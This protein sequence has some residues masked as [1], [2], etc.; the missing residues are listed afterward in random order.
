[1][2]FKK[3]FFN[4]LPLFV[5][6]RIFLFAVAYLS[7]HL[8]PAFGATFPYSQERLIS[9][10][11]PHFIWAFGNFDGV[12]YLGIADMAYAA[13]YTQAFFPIFPV[14]IKLASTL[15]GGNLLIAALVVS[16]SAFLLALTIFYKLIAETY[17]S[18]TALWSAV[19]LLS[20]PTSFYFGAV[21]T[22][23]I[24]FLLVISAFY[25]ANRNK[26]ILASIIGAFASATRLVGVFLAVALALKKKTNPFPPLL[27]VPLGLV[28]YMIYLK[29]EFNQPLYFLTSQAIFGQER[30]TTSIVLLP[31]VL[32]RYLKIA[33]TTSGQTLQIALF[34]LFS[35]LFAL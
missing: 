16:N 27:I 3:V 1:M 30:S 5:L 20:F 31:Q 2:S 23:G 17:N 10:H 8:I 18:K 4:I 6:W 7:P 14:L 13:Q 24:F 12:H 28:G 19:F 35:T 25:L 22:E 26:I 34:E 21:Y 15:T 32:Y 9:T 11:L 29:L 33:S